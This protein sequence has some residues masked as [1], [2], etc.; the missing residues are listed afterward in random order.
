[1]TDKGYG[2]DRTGDD[3]DA[4][5]AGFA[6]HLY[7]AL[8]PVRSSRAIAASAPLIISLLQ[9]GCG[10]AEIA[11][12]FRCA[13]ASQGIDPMAPSSFERAARRAIG[14]QNFVRSNG[15]S[16]A[17]PGAGRASGTIPP[18]PGTPLLETPRDNRTATR[19]DRVRALLHQ[20]DHA[21]KVR[22]RALNGGGDGGQ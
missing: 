14:T 21:K 8:G 2:N 4:I 15:H 12:A 22:D 17:P 10:W 18:A 9:Q 19:A 5:I 3:R 1:M 6:R 11:D 16:P 7:S 20:Q 13:Q